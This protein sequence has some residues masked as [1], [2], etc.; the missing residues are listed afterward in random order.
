MSWLEYGHEITIYA[1]VLFVGAEARL[2]M[3]G[4][5]GQGPTGPSS[6]F[7]LGAKLSDLVVRSLQP[8]PGLRPTAAE[9]IEVLETQRAGRDTPTRV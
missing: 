7:G 4:I 3:E 1:R 2:Q 5:K 9:I 8:D 6:V